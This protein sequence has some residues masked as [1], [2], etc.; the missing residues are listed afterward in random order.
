MN[1]VELASNIFRF[2]KEATYEESGIVA[3]KDSV[4]TFPPS[5]TQFFARLALVNR[6]FFYESTGVL[7][8]KM[9]SAAPFFELLLPADRDGDGKL[10]EPLVCSSLP[11][12]K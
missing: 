9:D 10:Y 1:T 3:T 2:L 4:P 6:T 11:C 8:E 12:S 7:W 5:W